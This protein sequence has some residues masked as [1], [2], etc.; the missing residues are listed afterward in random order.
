MTAYSCI[1]VDSLKRLNSGNSASQLA[2]GQLAGGFS[3]SLSRS[4]S[5]GDSYRIVKKK[6]HLSQ[7]SLVVAPKTFV[8]QCAADT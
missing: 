2:I 7:F 4:V 1:H 8:A 6:S 5:F 3:L